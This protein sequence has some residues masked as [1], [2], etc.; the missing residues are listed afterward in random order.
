MRPVFFDD[1]FGW[2]HPPAPSAGSGP[3][4]VL[5]PPLGNEA[6][7]T[8]R[9]WMALAATLASRGMPV[10]RFDYPGT[11]DSADPDHPAGLAD[12]LRGVHAAIACLRAE[13][14]VGSV[15]LCG[16]RLGAT[17]AWLA[18]LETDG[19]AAVAMLAPVISGRSWVRELRVAASGSSLAVLDPPPGPDQETPLNS[20]GIAWPHETLRAIEAIDLQKTRIPPVPRVL[21]L[22]RGESRQLSQFA[23]T[24]EGAGLAVL[25]GGF[26]G[27]D[28]LMNDPVLLH[29]PDQAFAQVADWL[30]GTPPCPPPATGRVAAAAALHTVRFQETPLCF[31][32]DESQA[33]PLF[34]M[35]CAPLTRKHD[36]AVL[37]VN[38]G[39][40]HHIGNGRMLVALARRL[41]GQGLA[42][43]RMDVAGMGDSPSWPDDTGSP[44]YGRHGP[45]D[46]GA[47][48]AALAARG[49]ERVVVMGLCAGAHL[50]VHAAL[51]Q[52]RIVGVVA[53][54]LQK[55]IWVPGTSLDIALR[56]AKRSFRSYLRSLRNPGEWRRLLRGEG[57]M[58]GIAAAMARRGMAGVARRLR[59]LFPP[60][61]GS[62][63]A[64][65]RG[66]LARLQGR[67]VRLL[68]V[69]ADD[70]PGLG[71]LAL[72]FGTGG[73]RL[74][75]LP[76]A[77][78][79]LL[80]KSDHNLNAL[81]ARRRF[82]RVLEEFL[83]DLGAFA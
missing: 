40:S 54:N 47:A 7:C 50:A 42:S 23:E 13:T 36:L 3:G 33:G 8:H 69:Y 4:V 67:G 74:R 79:V 66:W 25:R 80:P 11:G 65:V 1:C 39:T 51:Q 26:P 32:P 43:L 61:P 34:G 62:P 46:V 48:I 44:L 53:V 20:N 71:E 10:L 56:R 29:V 49:Y 57:D 21:L 35:L 75:A 81:D 31:G 72:Y 59:D 16:L 70:D 45:A 68:F 17:L 83:R 55:F 37:M 24:L 12:W 27:Y 22:Q 73:H 41:A 28:A 64:Q 19:I 60:R 58:I 30:A 63:V 82:E 6:I 2:I 78:L 15:A 76:D 14:G 5:C 77:R 9:E 18:T 52:P 38:T